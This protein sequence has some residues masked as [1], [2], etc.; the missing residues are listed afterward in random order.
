MP[1]SYILFHLVFVFS[2]SSPSRLPLVPH[3]PSP[4]RR[5]SD[6]FIFNQKFFNDMTEAKGISLENIVYYKDETHYFVM[7]AKKQ[8]LLNKGVI[9][10]NESDTA[11]LLAPDN[12]CQE[13]LFE[14]A[15]EAADFST[16]Y[17]LPS[18]EFAVNH[19]GKPDVAMFDFTSMFQVSRMNKSFIDDASSNPAP[20]LLAQTFVL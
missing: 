3:P 19:Y 13:R 16:G 7:T 18:L 9:L 12:I 17:G 6:L 15:R 10:K 11:R 1:I 20:P 2:C 8:S 14:Y 5:S 4:T